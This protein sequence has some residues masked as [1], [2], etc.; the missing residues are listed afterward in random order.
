M[1]R[2][3][4]T[5]D[6]RLFIRTG[7]GNVAR[8]TNGEPWYTRD[9]GKAEEAL[10]YLALNHVSRKRCAHWVKSTFGVEG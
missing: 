6:G 9:S 10:V 7:A 4:T 2:I 8:C 1:T 3:E 5:A